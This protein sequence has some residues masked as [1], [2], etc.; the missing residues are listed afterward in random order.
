MGQFV[1]NGGK[2]LAG[3]IEVGG[4]KNAAL[5]MIF[6]CILVDGITV[7]KNVPEIGDVDVAYDILRSLGAKIAYRNDSVVIDTTQLRYA[8]PNEELVSK[9]R[10]SSYLLGATLGRFGIAKIQRFGGCNFDNRPIDM[11]LYAAC[12]LGAEIKN[13]FLVAPRLLAADI[14]FDKI[15]VGATVNAL[16]MTVSSK[17]VSRIFGYAKEPHVISLIDFFRSCGVKI[18]LTEQCITVYGMQP[19]PCQATVI[20]D[21]IEAGTYIALSLLLNSEL[22]IKG[23]L[24]CHLESFLMPFVESGAVLEYDDNTIIASAQI[25]EPVDIIT[26]PY[27]EYP[28]DLHPQTVPLL[29]N[30]CGGKIVEGVWK[31]RFGYLSELRK[32]GIQY[33]LGDGTASIKKSVII[34]ARVVAPDLRGGA[35]LVLAALFANGESVI[36]NSELIKRGYANITKKLSGIGA[37]IKEI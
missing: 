6:S 9:I 24:F 17:G 20:P 21:M 25:T 22:K 15:S 34:P 19:G 35:A 2:A 5:P 32:F 28:T 36:E 33:E 12:S 16:M 11:H 13:G 8:V 3:E 4:S 27:P 14:V 7:L 23:A 1:I 29:A 26:A 37:D 30:S 31:N 10:A 18:E